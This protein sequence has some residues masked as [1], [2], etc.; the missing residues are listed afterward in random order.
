[1]SA[2]FGTLKNV[3]AGGL[4]GS[5]TA[6]FFSDIMAATMQAEKLQAAL[7]ATTGSKLLGERQFEQVRNMSA[8]IGL[9]VESAARSMIQL[10]SAGM[11]AAESM[12]LIKA[13]FNA[14]ASSGGGSEEFKRV[15]YG[16]QQV[17]SA[18]RF[19][20]EDINIIREALPTAGKLM[21]EAF[22]ANRAE[23]LQKLN[24]STREFVSGLIV[25]MEKLPQMG[26]TL[27]KQIGRTQAKWQ[28][29]L[30]DL[31]KSFKIGVGAGSGGADA[32]LD[33]TME[34]RK[35]QFDFIERLSGGDPE[36]RR[37]LEAMAA[38]IKEIQKESELAKAKEL[39]D[40]AKDA[41]AKN[42]SVEQ[43]KTLAK[44]FG[45]FN[46][47]I[48]ATAA[49][50]RELN[51]A[52]DFEDRMRAFT[53]QE[54]ANAFEA[55]LD[56]TRRKTGEAIKS[57]RDAAD[58]ARLDEFQGRA[59]AGDMLN[60]QAQEIWREKVARAGMTRGERK[61]ERAS[62]REQERNIRKAADK[63]T[64]EDMRKEREEARKRQF[65][66][67]K[68]N[69]F[70]DEEGTKRRLRDQNRKEASDAVKK[71]AITL[72]EIRDILKTLATA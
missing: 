61:A 58:Q 29:L 40:A 10:Q 55:S 25:A 7:S 57:K 72:G 39:E 32:L 12:R 21:Q 49:S 34:A 37:A 67:L 69:K 24:I 3:L 35:V 5:A 4:V 22:G 56:E 63:Q 60:A 36:K 33:L 46:D 52:L 14:V 50:A 9:N 68:N 59:D 19:L 43:G 15:A 18:G 70:F 62:E 44:V 6:T 23:D 42:K 28:A 1:M 54:A 66:D 16:M 27:E 30:A 26:D 71:S 8:D 41:A 2:Q 47:I 11:S 38:K 53:D 51:A 45:K 13:G 17:L 31:G 48:K 64:R 20:Q 65:D